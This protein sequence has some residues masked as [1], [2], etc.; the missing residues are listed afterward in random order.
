MVY[1]LYISLNQG[2]SSSKLAKLIFVHHQ[3]H[4][5]QYL[6]VLNVQMTPEPVSKHW[7]F[8]EKTACILQ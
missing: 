5:V 8:M 2:S 1:K 6:Q 7:F 3:T 4:K